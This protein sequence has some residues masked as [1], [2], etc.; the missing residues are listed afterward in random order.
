MNFKI[1][2]YFNSA[3]QFILFNKKFGSKQD[4]KV[5]KTDIINRDGNVLIFFY[6]NKMTGIYQI[7]IQFLFLWP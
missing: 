3:Y 7:Q 4:I 6:G 1:H 2:N 5:Y